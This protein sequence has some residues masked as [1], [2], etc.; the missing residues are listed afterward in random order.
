[1]RGNWRDWAR[2]IGWE[3]DQ[4]GFWVQLGARRQRVI[5][6]DDESGSR[7]F[8]SRVARRAILNRV[9]E[10]ELRAWQRNRV[11]ELVA[12]R[13]DR[14]GVMVAETPIPSDVTRDEWAFL[15]VN[16]ARSADRFEY[17]LTG[18]DEE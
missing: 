16:L 18:R 14:H 7:L 9:S 3:S 2:G 11:S 4:D 15:A 12:F 1:M 13:I 6:I 5:V 17:V 10:P 8:R